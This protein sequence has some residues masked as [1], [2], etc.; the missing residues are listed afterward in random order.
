MLS[1]KRRQYFVYWRAFWGAQMPCRSRRSV[2]YAVRRELCGVA[3]ETGFNGITIAP[4]K[5]IVKYFFG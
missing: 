3:M 4:R 1:Q 5:S 2:A